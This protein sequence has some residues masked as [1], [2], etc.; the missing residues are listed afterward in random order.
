MDEKDL[1]RINI[2]RE[3]T[4]ETKA[5]MTRASERARYHTKAYGALRDGDELGR[6]ECLSYLLGKPDRNPEF[7][8][9]S[10][11]VWLMR[12]EILQKFRNAANKIIIRRRVRKRYQM[13][14]QKLL[15]VNANTREAV[16]QFVDRD[17]RLA[18][19]AGGSSKQSDGQNAEMNS[20]DLG[21]LIDFVAFKEYPQSSV[22]NEDSEGGENDGDGLLSPVEA[23]IIRDFDHLDSFS[24]KQP[25]EAG[26]LNYNKIPELAVSVYVRT[27]MDRKLRT[28]AEEEE[29]V[30]IS[31]KVPPATQ[32]RVTVEG[33][34]M[35]GKG[36]RD[37]SAALPS[38]DGKTVP[39]EKESD[40]DTEELVLS[41][42]KGYEQWLEPQHIEPKTLLRPDASVRVFLKLDEPT[43]TDPSFSLKP[44]YIPF[45][46]PKIQRRAIVN[47]PGCS[48]IGSIEG[49]AMVSSIYRPTRQ[50]RF[51]SLS[52]YDDGQRLWDARDNLIQKL[53]EDDMMSDTDSDDEPVE[54][55][56]PIYPSISMCRNLFEMDEEA[57]DEGRK[58]K[59]KIKMK[60][61]MEM[62]KLSR[63]MKLLTSNHLQNCYLCKNH[64]L[65]N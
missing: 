31:A 24:L 5:S 51:S 64:L 23:G 56:E 57:I 2:A 62:R 8:I 39:G 53:S 20:L 45:N 9:Y 47:Q 27:E 63:R 6:A 32:A 49:V 42:P 4:T 52:Y 11:N 25:Y 54:E 26:L 28:G 55:D 46:P 12:K 36:E 17:N 35:E 59:M 40:K 10:N 19:N 65:E 13:L 61:L 44:E 33:D 34:I 58:I 16:K 38:S 7:D 30:R 48:S 50:Q 37:S 15:S 21:P 29:P 3:K 14:R 41:L 22:G 43:E 60:L 18:A 1:H